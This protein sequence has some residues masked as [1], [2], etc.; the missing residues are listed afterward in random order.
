[1]ANSSLRIK[2]MA[3]AISLIG[4]CTAAIG[5]SQLGGEGPAAMT[6]ALPAGLIAAGLSVAGLSAGIAITLIRG[7]E[8]PL[9][10]IRGQLDRF[11]EGR[12]TLAQRIAVDEGHEEAVKVAAGTDRYIDSI[13][14]NIKGLVDLAMGLTNTSTAVGYGSSNFVN[15]INNAATASERIEAALVEQQTQLDNV[16]QQTRGAVGQA[17]TARDAAEQGGSAVRSTIESVRRLG[18]VIDDA[19]QQVRA[20]QT[21]GSEIA[22]AADSIGDIAE[23]T[24]MLALN[25]AIEAARA[26]EHGRGFAVVADEVGK[27]AER[28]ASSAAQIAELVRAITRDTDAIVASAA[29]G[30]EEAAKG[31]E[32]AGEAGRGLE[33][34]LSE[35][36]GLASAVE[37]ISE[38]AESQRQAGEHV[39]EAVLSINETVQTAN[40]EVGFLSSNIEELTTNASNLASMLETFEVDRRDEDNRRDASDAGLI[41]PLGRVVDLSPGGLRLETKPAAKLQPNQI[42]PIEIRRESRPDETIFQAEARVIWIGRRRSQRGRVG[43]EFT[44]EWTDRHRGDLEALLKALPEQSAAT[45]PEHATA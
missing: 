13:T 12:G 11:A 45:S 42:V 34:I 22:A 38:S 39:R 37:S 19:G 31:E 2:T 6:A 26:G 7:L 3:S 16:I 27:L 18:G 43:L 4:L 21:R 10:E 30:S 40:E 23:Q 5:V 33:G 8:R 35:V 17:S 9:A 29:D 15:H 44:G 14:K 24:N 1:M 25:A 20:L 32:R 36:G 41:T 28:S